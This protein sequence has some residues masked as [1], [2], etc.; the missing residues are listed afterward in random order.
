MKTL[1]IS[2][3]GAVYIIASLISGIL[4]V[5]AALVVLEDARVVGAIWNAFEAT[6]SEKARALS[7]IRHE[8]GYGGMIHHFKNFILRGEP[9]RRVLVEQKIGGAQAA[10]SRFRTLG[11]GP[12]EETALAGIETVLRR[13]LAGL[14]VADSLI[15]EDIDVIVVD[16]A[17]S[18][19]DRPAFDGLETLNQVVNV[20]AMK[21]RGAIK[22]ALLYNL[23]AALGYGGMIHQFKN[24]VLRRDISRVE[25]VRSDLA[26]IRALLADY[27][28][29]SLTPE[30]ER[31]LTALAHVT[32]AYETNLIHAMEMAEAGASPRD[33]D[34]TV[35]VDD[36]PAL[37]G[38]AVLTRAMVAEHEVA[39]NA[40]A[41]GVRRIFRIVDYQSWAVGAIVSIMIALTVW[42]LR[43]RIVLPLKELTDSMRGLADGDLKIAIPVAG[44]ETEI[45]RM[46]KTMEIFRSNEIERRKAEEEVKERERW[47]RALLESAPDATIIAD[48]EG[49]IQLVNR[50]TEVL[51]GYAASELVGEKVE[52]LVP[53]SVRAGHAAHRIDFAN[54][55][56]VRA[57]GRG[58]ELSGQRKSGQ[59]FP[60][61]VSLSPIQ[62]SLGLN[63]AAAVRDITERKKAEQIIRDSENRIRTIM[64]NAADGIITIGERGDIQSFSPAATRIFGYTSDEVMGKNIKMLMPEPMRSE[65]DGYL[66]RYLQGG[67]PRIV[68]QNREV[69]GLRKDGSDFPMD[70]AVGEAVL[71]SE[72]V[73]T[74]IVRDISERKKAEEQ[75]ADAYSIIS[76][77]ID[78]ASYIQRSI[79]PHSDNFSTVFDDH[80][81]IW[82]PRDRVGG[83]VY[84]NR[85][86]GGG[87]LVML[88]DCTGHGVPGAFMTLISTGALDRA[89]E[90]IE[91]GDVGKL[92]HRMHQLVQLTLGQ[93]TEG[94]K[95][96]DGL[97]LGACYIDGDRTRLTFAGARF[98]L[99]K[100]EGAEVEEIK[101]DKQGIGYRGIPFGQEFMNRD[102]ALGPGIS[103]YLTT[104]GLID[105]VGGEKRRSYGKKRF[106]ELICKISDRPIFEQKF[107]IVEALEEYQGVERRRDDM[108]VIGFRIG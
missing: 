34:R 78:Y 77:S 89:S 50:Q 104:D 80:F 61:E 74:G 90:E 59:V 55:A 23:R 65:H 20:E 37:K 70:L 48:A 88:A 100:F 24:F 5:G 102:V 72:R 27:V 1:S 11:V 103:F 26:Y 17:A 52:V 87:V 67:K 8:M 16:R 28:A 82:E 14:K 91:P 60:I 76:D 35:K 29:L 54:L 44:E 51:F 30:E 63:V 32:T 101:G 53:E 41:D 62:A 75:L 18:V 99:F 9:M 43:F 79:L 3:L 96:D 56:S 105:Q 81:V 22:P 68:G 19:N 92:L 106:K 73:F 57:M 71:G 94:G 85:T 47:F 49:T 33:I 98:S 95:S 36:N 4:L 66:Q 46:A 83:D 107:A 69:I 93:H 86:W 25:K 108:S 2:R 7:S 40:L 45:G 10:I 31:A 39:A 42:V 6:R 21:T 38:L 12:D 13:Y 58:L 97:E 15:G 84:W 64:N